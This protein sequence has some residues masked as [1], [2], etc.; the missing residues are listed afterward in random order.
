MQ[1]WYAGEA[2]SLPELD[3]SRPKRAWMVEPCQ[4][5]AAR[6]QQVY[7]YPLGKDR[8]KYRVMSVFVL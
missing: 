2:K 8:T 7:L 4:A 6:E 1:E 3:L 5:N